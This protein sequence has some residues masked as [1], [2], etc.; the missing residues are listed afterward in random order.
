MCLAI[1]GQ[2]VHMEADEGLFKMGLVDFDGVRKRVVLN[3]VPE[4][5][6]GDYVIVHVGFAISRILVA[7]AQETFAYLR[8]VLDDEVPE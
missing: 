6:P 3:Y 2:I 1:P 4:A 5:A 7:E 8:K